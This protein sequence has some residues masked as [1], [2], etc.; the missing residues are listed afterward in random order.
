MLS[1]LELN[2]QYTITTTMIMAE[3]DLKRPRQISAQHKTIVEENY[4]HFW[5]ASSILSTPFVRIYL[6]IHTDI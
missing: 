1:S 2:D 5:P 4:A 3:N 6:Y